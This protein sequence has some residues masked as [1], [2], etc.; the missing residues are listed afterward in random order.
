M[1]AATL[2]VL[3]SVTR[4]S[5]DVDW[6][7]F[8]RT[9]DSLKADPRW[10]RFSATW[11]EYQDDPFLESVASVSLGETFA[12]VRDEPLD[13]PGARPSWEIGIQSVVYATF[14]PLGQSQPL[15]NSDWQIGGYVAG[16]SGPWSGMLRL[17]H[18]SSHL[19][20]EFLIQN[21]GFPR[22]NFTFE[23]LSGLGSY[24]PTLWS[25]IYGGGG[26]IFDE[27]PTDFGNFF[28]QYGL[29]LRWP[30]T[31]WRDYARPFAAVDVQ[32]LEATDWQADVSFVAGV[33][34]REPNRDAPALRLT[35]EFYDG[36]N[37]NGQFFGDDAQYF[38]AGLQLHL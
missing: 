4:V 17:W 18:Q 35:V 19:G 21:P 28:V 8:A 24:E 38:G 34:F 31:V 7:A 5:A 23:S 30:E 29:E 14:E 15:F 13:E 11:Q 2:L 16:R 12:I 33:E 3:L 6:L 20:D 37:P 9:F 32:H 26:W 22:V 36:R 10:P 27:K 1:L 25:R